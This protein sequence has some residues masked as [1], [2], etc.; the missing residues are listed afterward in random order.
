MFKQFF[1]LVLLACLSIQSYADVTLPRVFSSHMVFQQQKP[2]LIWGKASPNETVTIRLKNS[3]RRVVAKQDGTWQVKFPAQQA[4]FESFDVIISGGNTIRLSDVLVGEVWLCSGQSNMEYTMQL[5]KGYKAPAKGK[6][7][8]L[9]ELAKPENRNIRLL[10]V[11]RKKGHAPDVET[12]GWQRCNSESLASFSAAGYFFG[13]ELLETLQVPIGLISS[14]WGGSRIEPW[15]PASAYEK[16]ADIQT[17]KKGSNTLVD[18]A[19]AGEMFEGMIR[20]LAPFALRGFLWYQGESNVMFE[21]AL[22]G[23]KQKV[24]IDAW[25]KLWKDQQL[26]FHYVQIAPYS[27]SRRKDKMQHTTE[28]LPWFWEIQTKAMD[29]KRS[30]MVVITDLVDDLSDI[31]PSYKWEVGRR[32]ALWA[33]AKDYAQNN[34][35]FSGPLYKRNHIQEGRI[36]LEFDHIGSGLICQGEQ[37]TWFEIAGA[38][39]SFVPAEAR[40]EGNKVI[41][42]S[43]AVPRPLY[44]RFAWSEQ[45]RPNFFNHEGLPAVPFRTYK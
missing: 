19:V 35:V 38:D 4:S 45:A 40:I 15:T 13:K 28:T 10:L 33:L 8:T 43:T 21:D 22:Y 29:P 27:Y 31:H 5:R 7:R 25:R 9:E 16:S 6:D 20:P 36:A 32:L 42:S 44:V 14:S 3:E 26:S 37:L 11:G 1:W 39:K 12:I 17:V 2:I 18:N 30:G 23:R 24:L 34:I 41:V